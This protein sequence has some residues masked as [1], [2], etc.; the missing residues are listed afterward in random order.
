MTMETNNA[1]L[2]G[3]NHIPVL[4]IFCYFLFLF[5]ILRKH[6]RSVPTTP[7]QSQPHSTSPILLPPHTP[8]PPET[9][10]L[11]LEEIENKYDSTTAGELDSSSSSPSWGEGRR[12]MEDSS[13]DDYENEEEKQIDEVVQ[14][15]KKIDEIP[16]VT[17]EGNEEIPWAERL[18]R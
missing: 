13:S 5:L 9:E 7:T 17:I 12:T 10:I 4:F 2:L 11:L 16:V 8:I 1:L 18:K 15:D 14:E 6:T 3:K